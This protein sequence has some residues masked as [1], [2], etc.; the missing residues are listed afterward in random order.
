MRVQLKTYVRSSG[1]TTTSFRV[2]FGRRVKLRAFLNDA[3]ARPDYV[4]SWS[5]FVVSR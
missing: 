5:N 2:H 1:A 3:S 4:R